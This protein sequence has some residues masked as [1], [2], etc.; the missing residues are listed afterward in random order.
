MVGIIE[1]IT[2]R[3]ATEIAILAARAE[4]ER[5]NAAKTE[6][7]SAMSHELRTPL[8]AILGF[9][10]LIEMD[11]PSSER[12]EWVGHILKSGHHLLGL[13]DEILDISR[14]ES[15]KIRLSLEPVHV[16]DVVAQTV[17]MLAPLAD[18]QG[19]RI[20]VDD[21]GMDNHVFADHQRFKQV[22]VNILS[23]ALKYN[24]THG[25]VALNA[26]QRRRRAC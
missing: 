5:A 6:F 25:S 18:Q 22:L 19:I 2:E 26:R 3:K 9:G 23:N 14:M 8:N 12:R 1:D 15:G 4:A 11:D 17:G 7:L 24:R 10:Q 21:H 13:I 20:V 16:G